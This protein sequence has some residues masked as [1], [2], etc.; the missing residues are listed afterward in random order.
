ML[1]HEFN[2]YQAEKTISSPPNHILLC[3]VSCQQIILVLLGIFKYWNLNTTWLS[4]SFPPPA[5]DSCFQQWPP[6][7][8]APAIPWVQLSCKGGRNRE[9]HQWTTEIN[10]R[11]ILWVLWCLFFFFHFC[12]NANENKKL[13]HKCN[14]AH[15]D[16]VGKLRERCFHVSYMYF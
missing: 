4:T 16:V 7:T 10:I 14:M 13:F 6:V 15:L 2:W 12:V 8:L 11:W 3:P 9:C 1:F 5:E